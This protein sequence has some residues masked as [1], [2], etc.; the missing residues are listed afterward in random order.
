MTWLR[1]ESDL[2]LNKEF[3]NLK[4]NCKSSN[5]CTTSSDKDMDLFNKRED[6][7]FFFFPSPKIFSRL[8]TGSIGFGSTVFLVYFLLDG[9]RIYQWSHTFKINQWSHQGK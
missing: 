3:G 8:S 5:V 7:L 6:E 1:S 9:A 4:S 2:D